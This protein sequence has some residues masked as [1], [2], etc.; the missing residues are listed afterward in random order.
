MFPYVTG[1]IMFH[2]EGYLQ[3]GSPLPRFMFEPLVLYLDLKTISYFL[4]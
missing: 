2:K 4:Q 1:K 3:P